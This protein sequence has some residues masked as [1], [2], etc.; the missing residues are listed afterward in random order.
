MPIDTQR[1]LAQVEVLAL[2]NQP[3]DD[4]SGQT[5][6]LTSFQGTLTLVRAVYG[7]DSPHETTLEAAMKT[8]QT[9]P[10]SY[11]WTLVVYVWPA[12]QGTLRALKGDVETG[13]LG[14]VR[15]QGDSREDR[16]RDQDR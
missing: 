7:P 6:I 12:V 11:S 8:A 1:V 5:S 16:W 15:R 13:L 3:P 9:K 4:P 14:D 2:P 10:G